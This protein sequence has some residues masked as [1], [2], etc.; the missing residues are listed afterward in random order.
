[1][2]RVADQPRPTAVHLERGL[3]LLL[4]ELSAAVEPTR[5]NVLLGSLALMAALFTKP[6]AIDAAL[7][8]LISISLRQPRLALQ[9]SVIVGGL[10]IVGLG[11]LMAL[12]HGAF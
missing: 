5:R 1:M 10:G 2:E 3:P 4:V 6:T 7:A 12:T 9:A 8:G 11:V